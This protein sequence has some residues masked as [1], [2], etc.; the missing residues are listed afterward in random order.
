M[1]LGGAATT[2]N[3]DGDTT[4]YFEE[5]FVNRIKNPDIDTY[6]EQGEFTSNLVNCF[7][8]LTFA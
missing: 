1:S 7:E 2:F 5:V 8:L 3:F 4:P 6:Q